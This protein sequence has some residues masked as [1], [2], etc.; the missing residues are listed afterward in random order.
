[1]GLQ[2]GN[3]ASAD[4]QQL[5]R[6]HLSQR[7]LARQPVPQQD[8]L[9]FPR[10][11]PLDE[12]PQPPGLVLLFAP[13]LHAEAVLQHIGE[14]EGRV[15]LS[16]IKSLLKREGGGVLPLPPEVHPE[17]VFDAPAGISGEAR[18]A[19]GVEGVHGFH[20][21][22]GADGNQIVLLRGESIVFLCDVRH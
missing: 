15:F 4:L 13:V 5:C 18:P 20:Q 8:Q 2:P 22:N 14:G 1:M 9:P 19:G 21:A 3:V 11:Q 12:L 7:R 6:F 16:G 10:R 17:R